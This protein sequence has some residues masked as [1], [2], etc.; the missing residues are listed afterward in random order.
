MEWVKSLLAKDA[1]KIV[2]SGDSILVWEDPW[3]PDLQEYKPRPTSQESTQVCMLV[4][5][6]MNQS[7]LGWE[8][9]LLKN[10]F[11]GDSV[12]AFLIF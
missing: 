1:Y 11:Y 3:I 4:S 9:G 12:K 5:H 2:G 8:V 6:L 7:K 10:L